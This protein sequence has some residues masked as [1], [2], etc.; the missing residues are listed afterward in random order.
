MMIIHLPPPS[1]VVIVFFSVIVMSNERLHLERVSSILGNMRQYTS[2][3]AHD[4]AIL[5]DALDPTLPVWRTPPFGRYGVQP[6]EIHRFVTGALFCTPAYE[7]PESWCSCPGFFE[8]L[9]VH[10]ISLDGTS[11]E[12]F[13]KF[14][15]IRRL[16]KARDGTYGNS[17]L[18]GE[19]IY[20]M[21]TPISGYRLCAQNMIHSIT[22]NTMI[23]TGHA[24]WIFRNTNEMARVLL[25]EEHGVDP[26]RTLPGG[27]HPLLAT[28]INAEW[29]TA[30]TLL[31]DPRVCS[32]DAD[33]S[34]LF[35]GFFERNPNNIKLFGHVNVVSEARSLSYMGRGIISA[36]ESLLNTPSL[37]RGHPELM[38]ALRSEDH[39]RIIGNRN[40]F[41]VYGLKFEILALA[42]ILSSPGEFLWE[43][44]ISPFSL[45][46]LEGVVLSYKFS[47]V[48]DDEPR[49]TRRV[50]R[51]IQNIKEALDDRD[52]ARQEIA[53]IPASPLFR[54][55]AW[56]LQLMATVIFCNRGLLRLREGQ[57]ITPQGRWLTIV[58]ALP[59]ELQME[60]CHEAIRL[61]MEERAELYGL[62]HPQS[63]IR[64]KS[65]IQSNTD[66]IV[67]AKWPIILSKCGGMS[68]GYS[69]VPGQENTGGSIFT[70]GEIDAALRSMARAEEGRPPLVSG[71]KRQR[72]KVHDESLAVLNLSSFSHGF[73]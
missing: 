46:G 72:W 47:R 15:E 45:R 18:A 73:L 39:A 3:D 49:L 56:A 21:R 43:W 51:A 16:M 42:T 69:R 41:E 36:Q 40:Y 37:A 14:R 59:P 58:C 7:W 23:S 33:I 52:L 67:P 30:R 28:C 13:L 50:H 54:P 60:H 53:E 19:V 17:G 22:L 44:I 27:I 70:T 34:R 25:E 68:W 12:R 29:E 6:T 64:V 61:A 62:N 5:L 8:Y 26:N 66:Y 71:V 11:K 65:T 2:S 48:L 35:T 24:L 20:G 57:E 1:T 32:G 31:R 63:C 4:A 38:D 9:H 55:R 10:V